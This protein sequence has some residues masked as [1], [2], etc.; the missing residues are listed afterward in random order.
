MA[1]SICVR[2]VDGPEVR[3]EVPRGTWRIQ[4][5]EIKRHVLRELMQ[6]DVRH[7]RATMEDVEE[8]KASDDERSKSIGD[9][10]AVSV[11]ASFLLFKGQILA[12]ADDVNLFALTPADF[13]VLA[14]ESSED[15]DD[16]KEEETE[17]KSKKRPREEHDTD[18]H[19]Q[20]LVEMGFTVE[21]ARNALELTGHD[22]ARAVAVLMGDETVLSASGAVNGSNSARKE[23]VEQLLRRHPSLRAIESV[24]PH[25]EMEELRIRAKQNTFQALVLLKESFSMHWLAQLNENPVATLEFLGSSIDPSELPPPRKT[26]TKKAQPIEV[27]SPT[28]VMEVDSPTPISKH[29]EAIERLTSMGFALDVVEMIY[30]SCG[31]NEEL[32]ANLLLETLQ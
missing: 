2:C 8:T 10:A 16:E 31:K 3:L 18:E 7:P 25:R 14:P 21:Q 17:H 11:H 29:Q 15:D 22:L 23:W 27:N 5:A 30:E 24:L 4:V 20:Q 19:A 1:T 28:K 6:M 12:D 13:F 26:T 32:A 9:D